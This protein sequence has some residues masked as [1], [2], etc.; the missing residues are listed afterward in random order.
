VNNEWEDALKL[1]VEAIE[2]L[3]PEL[4]PKEPCVV[5]NAWNNAKKLLEHAEPVSAKSTLNDSFKYP[6]HLETNE[7]PKPTRKEWEEWAEIVA[8]AVFPRDDRWDLLK[9]AILY[10]PGVPKEQ[11]CE[12]LI[13]AWRDC[14][15]CVHER[16]IGTSSC[17]ECFDDPARPSWE[18]KEQPEPRKQCPSGNPSMVYTSEPPTRTRDQLVRLNGTD[19][20]EPVLEASDE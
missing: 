18:K 17:S 14:C 13:N 9:Q 7:P 11:P 19:N 20:P 12:S 16:E 1:C 4:D 10:I 2:I 3:H 6:Y 5:Y 8:D 15:D